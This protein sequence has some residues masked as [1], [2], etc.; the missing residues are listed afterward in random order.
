M[1]II[2]IIDLIMVVLVIFMVGG[3]TYLLIGKY[4]FRLT[5]WLIGS[6]RLMAGQDTSED[7]A[8]PEFFDEPMEKMLWPLILLLVAMALLILSIVNILVRGCLYFYKRYRVVL[9]WCWK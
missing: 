5:T 1:H 4:A 3:S 8:A 6:M 2:K 7:T 9:K